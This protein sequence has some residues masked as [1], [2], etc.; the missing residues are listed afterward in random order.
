MPARG[1]HHVHHMQLAS[2]TSSIASLRVLV[3]ACAALGADTRLFLRRLQVP[4]ALLRDDDARIAFATLMRAWELA[5]EM[6]GDPALGLHLGSRIPRGSFGLV[7]HAARASRTLGDA[8]RC[9]LAYQR[10]LH[11]RVGFSLALQGSRAVLGARVTGWPGGGP[12]HYNEALIALLLTRARELTGTNLTP[13]EIA[14]EHRAPAARA[15]HRRILRAPL[16][17]GAAQ[18]QLVLPATA[19]ALPL[20]ERDDTLAA[21]L[22]RFARAELA[23]LG[24][25]SDGIHLCR[26]MLLTLVAAGH[27]PR[28]AD[29]ADNLGAS[30]RSL[31]RLLATEGWTFR[32]LLDDVRR[33]LALASAERSDD[34]AAEIAYRLGFGDA[35]ALHHAFRRWTG[36]TLGD[37]RE[38]VKPARPEA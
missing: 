20:R 7:E 22:D 32:A 2:S 4:A 21:V 24:P 13:L 18:N 5:P 3:D 26:G 8:I 36:T 16:R 29:L 23:R 12:R 28:L 35:S 25:A 38:R 10:L 27:V 30:T 31:Q 9:L 19:L 14:F 37:Y 15:E 34:S 17:F 6:V 1:L 11:D 33:E